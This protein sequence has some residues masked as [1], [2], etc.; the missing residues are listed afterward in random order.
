MDISNVAPG[1]YQLASRS[2]PNNVIEETDESNN[3]YAFRA[4]VV[5][6]YLPKALGVGRVEPGQSAGITLASDKFVSTCFD[7][8][9]SPDPGDA[10][11]CNPG[12]VRYR[13]TTVPTRG[14]IRQGGTTLGVGST[15]SSGAITYTANAGQRGAD[16]FTYEAFDN[17]RPQY[18]I[19]KPQ[20]AVA[21]QV[22]APVV[23]VAI[24]GAQQSIVAGLSMQLSAV[25]TNSSGGVTWSTSAGSISP[26]GLFTAPSKAGTVTIRAT[27]TEDPSATAAITVQVTAPKTQGPAPTSRDPFPRLTAGSKALS[28]LKV[29]R[30]ATRSFV[31]KA[32]AGA[33]G[34]T[35]KWTVKSGKT[36][37]KTKNVTLKPRKGF[38]YRVTLK[39]GVT[40][41]KVRITARFT[42]KG[43]R[44]AIVRTSGIPRG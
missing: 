31:A 2:D 35:L 3:G 1:N 21:I 38:I 43:T 11:Y 19:Q 7:G 18:P 37:L 20:A 42:P 27:S 36:V 5:P 14:V 8:D 13:I 17:G 39:R 15:L 23:S 24:S 22:G 6:G 25:L 44:T 26:T 12:A 32:V 33:K 34:G 40:I 10:P 4:A 9:F 16:G 30:I 41:S 28:P 29:K